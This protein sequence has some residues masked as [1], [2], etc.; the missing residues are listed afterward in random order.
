MGVVSLLVWRSMDRGT[1]SSPPSTL[2]FAEVHK[3]VQSGLDEGQLAAYSRRLEG[4]RVQWTGTVTGIDG[5]NTV[6]LTM[7]AGGGRPNVQFELP[8]E[9]VR[10]VRKDQLVT[11]VGTIQNV[12]IVQTFPPMPNTY[13]VLDKA[14]LI[15]Q[16]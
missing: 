10:T 6:Y 9:V 13:L 14:R 4:T 1:Q 16:P 3:I 2:S 11:F 5:D 7:S 15:S 12:S 8:E